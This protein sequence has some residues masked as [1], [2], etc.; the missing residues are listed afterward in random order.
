MGG[1][2]VRSNMGQLTADLPIGVRQ[3][4]TMKTSVTVWLMVSGGKRQTRSE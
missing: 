2:V 4:S 3:A 1:Q